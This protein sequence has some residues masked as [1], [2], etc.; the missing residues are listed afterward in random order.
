MPTS[1]TPNTS[2]NLPS[3]DTLPDSALLDSRTTAALLGIQNE[4]LANW[5]STGRYG[6]PYT[7]IGRLP[8]YR[9]GDIRRFI[10]ERT[11]QHTGQSAR[12]AA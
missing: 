4:T 3:L 10:T 1:N 8:R 7:L 2:P 9:A 11:R 6:L 5:R 12:P